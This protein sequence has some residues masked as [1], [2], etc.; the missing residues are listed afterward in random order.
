MDLNLKLM[1][2][3]LNV[4]IYVLN[5]SYL[6]ILNSKRSDEYKIYIGFTMMCGFFVCDLL[7]LEV[8]FLQSQTLKTFHIQTH[9]RNLFSTNFYNF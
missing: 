1:K 2:S 9:I 7:L 6:C 3:A 8:N 4:F 5:I